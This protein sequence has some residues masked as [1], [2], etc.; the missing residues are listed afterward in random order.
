MPVTEA[1]CALLNGA[2]VGGVIGAL[3]SRP[4]RDERE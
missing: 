4:L 3:L 1:V 2:P